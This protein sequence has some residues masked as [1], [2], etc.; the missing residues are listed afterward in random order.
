MTDA[1]AT[2]PT[3]SVVVP[4]FNEAAV[5]PALEARLCAVLDAA[6]PDHEVVFVDD[7]SADESPTILLAV[8][9]RNP[10]VRVLRFS[11]NFG[12]QAAVTA[13]IEHARGR[14]IVVIDA[15]LQDPPEV[16]PDLL[17]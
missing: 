9:A 3:L 12:H 7:G 16:I 17:A 14:A 4:V 5:L 1:D 2:A 10:R 11:R 15:D 8:A 6:C 13:G